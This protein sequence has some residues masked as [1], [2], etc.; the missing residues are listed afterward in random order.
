MKKG[1]RKRG[2]GSGLRCQRAV[3]KVRQDI[4]ENGNFK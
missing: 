3:R 2:G 4:D 1:T